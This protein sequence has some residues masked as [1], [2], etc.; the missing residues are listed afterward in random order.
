MNSSPWLRLLILIL[1]G[2]G[3]AAVGYLIQQKRPPKKQNRPDPAAWLT[4]PVLVVGALD[5]FSGDSS[6]AS[7]A[8]LVALVALLGSRLAKAWHGD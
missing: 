7:Q 4:A 6:I 5:A 1:L 3:L 2:A 8:C